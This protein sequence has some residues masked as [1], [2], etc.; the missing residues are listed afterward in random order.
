MQDGLAVL[1]AAAA[2][3]EGAVAPAAPRGPGP[4]RRWRAAFAHARREAHAA[5]IFAACDARDAEAL[6]RLLDARSD[7]VDDY[8]HGK[9]TPLLAVCAVHACAP[10]IKVLLRH[11]ADVNARGHLGRTPLVRSAPRE[12]TRAG[13]THAG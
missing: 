13:C 4:C 11:G 2:A 8:R 1:A 12:A 7:C 5:A 10:A 3:E 9:E 6:A